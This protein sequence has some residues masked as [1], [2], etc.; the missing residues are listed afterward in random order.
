M[1][2]KSWQTP[3]RASSASSMGESTRVLCGL[4]SNRADISRMIRRSVE[5]GSSPRSSRQ[6]AREIVEQRRG[7]REHARSQVLPELARIRKGIERVPGVEAQPI[8]QPRR[9]R[10]F[11]ERFSGQRQ[12]GVTRRDVEVM[13]DVAVV[14]L[15]HHHARRGR[16]CQ[17]EMQAPLA[18]V[19]PRLHARLHH[20]LGDRCVVGEARDVTDGVTH[21]AASRRRSKSTVNVRP[22]RLATPAAPTRSD[23]RCRSGRAPYGSAR[24]AGRRRSDTRADLR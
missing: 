10:A 14:V 5:S 4:Y 12:S 17:G 9:R 24:T 16:R 3:R 15:V 13:D 21:R 19:A 6:L 1:C 18:A 2:A 7:S 20:A 23:T 11:D 8:G 22:E